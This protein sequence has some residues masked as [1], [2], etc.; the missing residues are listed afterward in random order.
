MIEFVVRAALAAALLVIGSEAA[1]ASPLLL[2]GIG[3]GSSQNRGRVVKVDES[4][5]AGIL[6][7]GAGVG[8]SAGLNG[9]AFSGSGA[10]YG[11]AV[12][13][14]VFADPTLGSPTLVRLN[15]MTGEVIS[16]LPITFA[17]SG[18]EVVDLAVQPDTGLVYGASFTSTSPG[19]SLYTIDPNTGAATLVGAT[20]VIGV[21]LAFAPDGILYMTS[22]TFGAS[23]QTG[24][25]LHT[26]DPATGAVLTGVD[27]A[28]TPSGNLLHVGGLA[29]RPTDNA[30]FASAREA[31][32]FTR[33]DIYRLTTTG[34]ATFVGSTGV[35]DVGD[36]DFTPIPEPSSVMLLGTAIAAMAAVRRRRRFL[37]HTRE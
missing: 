1:F 27:I 6:L 18:L 5:A 19:T 2:G 10:L 4:S 33:G 11:S 37:R 29:V 3:F 8:P 9:L 31:N 32:T 20:G 25:F 24:S 36:L 30:L 34:T 28:V 26:V 17:G 21:S 15:P 23:G 35:G 12:S 7:P 16:S 13:N 22:A 14:P